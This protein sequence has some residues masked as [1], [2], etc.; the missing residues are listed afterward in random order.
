M[1]RRAAKSHESR[2]HR[3]N[4][5]HY[6]TA[7]V[8]GNRRGQT[9]SPTNT[10]TGDPASSVSGQSGL[11]PGTPPLSATFNGGVAAQHQQDVGQGRASR[12]SDF[13][14]TQAAYTAIAGPRWSATSTEVL[15]GG[16][17]NTLVHF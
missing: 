12:A 15:S 9:L 2:R 5:H 4:S 1:A 17:G 8:Y 14:V 13:A 11:S 6:A 16:S 10:A 7:R 3:A